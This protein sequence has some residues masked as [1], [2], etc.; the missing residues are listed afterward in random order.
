MHAHTHI[1]LSGRQLAEHQRAVGGRLVDGVTNQVKVL[2]HREPREMVHLRDLQGDDGDGRGGG[3]RGGGREGG[4]SHLPKRLY[5]R[6]DIEYTVHHC[7]YMYIVRY[8]YMYILHVHVHVHIH[9]STCT[10]HL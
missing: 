5:H 8:V 7:M 9:A 4:S 10:L 1:A 6:W 3:G 2:Q